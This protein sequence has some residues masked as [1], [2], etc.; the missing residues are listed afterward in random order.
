MK[1]LLRNVEVDGRVV[2]VLVAQGRIAAVEQHIGATPT[3]N[4]PDVTIDGR[5]GSLLPGLHDHH[6]HLLAIA[7]AHRSVDCSPVAVRN[8]AGLRR[9]LSRAPLLDGWI[10]GTG[11]HESVA[12]ALDRARLD[13]WVSDRPVRI[14]HRGGALWMLNS[15]ALE[16]VSAVLD[17]SADVERD[18]DGAPTGRLW[19]YDARLRPALPQTEPDLAT[20]GE[21]LTRFGITGVTDATPDIDSDAIALLGRARVRGEL[22]PTLLLGAPAGVELPPGLAAGPFKLL[23]RDH[24]LPDYEALRAAVVANHER[25]RAVAVHCVTREALLLTLAVLDDAGPLAGDRIE[26]AGVVPPGIGAW[27]AR[28][29]LR[30]VTQPGFLAVRGDDYL[31]EV[32]ADDC[33]YLYPF[34]GLLAAGVPTAA[35]SDAPFGPLDPWA[36]I[37]AAAERRTA[38]GAV[39][40]AAE[41]VDTVTA[42]RGYLTA[43]D[44]PGGEPRRVEVGARGGLCLLHLPLAEALAAPTASAVRG[45]V[46][47]GVPRLFD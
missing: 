8:A 30:V 44:D 17:D 38:A 27:I 23:L 45:V 16:L 25:H 1:L 5:G 18:A 34:A 24:D 14:Q 31:R 22:P 46:V 33:P 26:H 3:A 35:S 15:R 39:L 29:G 10:R 19:R 40:G 43:A 28:L 41:R 12:G 20:V 4:G 36:V 13:A 11:Y 42:L 2:D 21:R 6:L 47:D 7:A 32:D 9:A 37:R